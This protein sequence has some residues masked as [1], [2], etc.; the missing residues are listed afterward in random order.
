LYAELLAILAERRTA[1]V[2][3]FVARLAESGA[4]LAE[5]VN[6]AGEVLRA[7]ML[8]V[9]VGEKA[10]A[11]DVSEAV[12]GAVRQHAGQFREGDVLRMLKLLAEAEQVIRRSPNARLHVET[13]LVQWTL[14]DRTVELEDIIAA[15]GGGS[16]GEQKADR[17]IGGSADEQKA[18]R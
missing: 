9:I 7:L 11:G 5:F 10:E 4:D 15:L 14:L 1:D 3:P 16:V 13:L 12:R 17:R 2:F 18:D 8:R 6:G